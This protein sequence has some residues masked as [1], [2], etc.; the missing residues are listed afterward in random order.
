M[1]IF[2]DMLSGKDP[3]GFGLLNG[4]MEVFV[5]GRTAEKKQAREAAKKAV[6]VKEANQQTFVDL[7]KDSQELSSIALNSPYFKNRMVNLAKTNPDLYNAVAIKSLGAR[8]VTPYNE[9]II[10][11]ASGNSTFAANFI[12]SNGDYLKQNPNLARILKTTAASPTL[13]EGQNR[14]LS[15]VRT[16]QDAVNLRDS[17]FPVIKT[18]ESFEGPLSVTIDGGRP[19]DTKTG[20][21]ITGDLTEYRDGNPTKN[22]LFWVLNARAEQED[23]FEGLS[24]TNINTMKATIKES[25]NP[26]QT[27]AKLKE[28]IDPKDV[29][30]LFF[31]EAFKSAFAKKENSTLTVSQILEQA[32]TMTSDSIKDDTT[33]G[34]F[35]KE[36]LNTAEIKNLAGGDLNAMLNS[37]DKKEQKNAM[38]IFAL[39]SLAN[40]VD[41]VAKGEGKSGVT[42]GNVTLF[43]AKI[44]EIGKN[45]ETADSFLSRMNNLNLKYNGKAVDI[46]GFLEVLPEQEKAMLISDITSTMKNHNTLVTQRTVTDS[47]KKFQERPIDYRISFPALYEI[48]EIKAFIHGPRL[49]QPPEGFSLENNNIANAQT[50]D[51]TETGNPLPANQFKL[52]NEDTVTVQPEVVQFANAKGFSKISDMLKDDG[53]FEALEGSGGFRANMSGVLEGNNKIFKA[54]NAIIKQVPNIS[55]V[56]MLRQK[57]FA[58]IARTIINQNIDDDADVFQVISTLMSD[59]FNIQKQAG[60]LGY[61]Q[62]QIDAAIQRLSKGQLNADDLAKQNNNLNAYVSTLN[63]AINNIGVQ[64]DRNNAAIA[65]ENIV[66]DLY[67]SQTG[68]IPSTIGFVLEKFQGDNFER[69]QGQRTVDSMNSALKRLT[70]D[71]RLTKDRR[72]SSAKLASNLITIAYQRAK[73]L[74]PNGRISDRDFKAALESIESSF[75]ASNQI[76]KTLLIGF[77]NDVE[78]QLTINENLLE[79]FTNTSTDNSTALLKKNIR[80]IRAVPA[81]KRIRQMISSINN[82]KEYRDRFTEGN[83]IPSNFSLDIVQSHNTNQLGISSEL[84]IYQVVRKTNTRDPIAVGLPVYT[85]KMGKMLTSKELAERGFRP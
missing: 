21:E 75:F 40:T 82:V 53:Y 62:E 19:V 66:T 70:A 33:R 25:E 60:T 10:T 74:D 45:R 39:K 36:I 22:S 17:Y 27:V 77:K 15:S 81:F 34:M 16:K 84:Q 69:D 61:S 3:V 14:I 52:K 63:S 41:K 58:S 12:A 47:G 85:D 32:V 37:T 5:A 31:L 55:N 24:D 29:K 11:Q 30:S 38:N 23:E 1:S 68:L 8:E 6:E 4:S 80:A 78:A 35:A 76:T 48:P 7:I 44:T 18:K 13:T 2:S 72:I 20:K 73:T 79:V 71:S 50:S 65:L 42:Y 9:K 64:G 67:S 56:A 51:G 26:I 49:G 28:R 59:D 83:K 54:S 46:K 43:P 57:D